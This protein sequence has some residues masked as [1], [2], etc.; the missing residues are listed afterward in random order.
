MEKEPTRDMR[1]LS[2][3]EIYSLKKD[4]VRMKKNK[5]S[6]KQI[7]VDLN[8]SAQTV[9]RVWTAYTRNGS[10]LRPAK[11]G[12]KDGECTILSLEQEREIKRIIV[13]KTPE[14]FKMLFMLWTREAVCQLIK[15]KYGIEMSLRSMSN[16]LER[17]GMTCQRPTKRAY[18]QDDVKVKEF[19]EK[20]YPSIKARAEAENGEIY[21]GDETGISNQE[22]YLRG[23]APKGE[24]PVLKVEAKR[25][26]IN[27]I[28]AINN[29]GTVRFLL[30]ETKMTQ[31]R[32][33]EFMER[34]IVDAKRKVFF[35]VDNL[36]VHHGNI[37]KE[38]L[39]ENKNRIELFFIP[40]Y[41]P[42]LNPDEYLNHA[43]KLGVHSEIPPRTK[44]DLKY[45]T[46]QFMYDLKANP[47]KVQAFFK[48]KKI[49]YQNA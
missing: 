12:R 6:Q 23:F 32:F 3:E 20:A 46:T 16:Y 22:H 40:P 39:A 36:K 31:Q 2:A 38:W 8:V 47:E 9:V 15:D 29:Y 35:I 30:Y 21:W 28:S 44:D 42:E 5:R 10:V 11:R 25:E 34:L 14:Q 17:W 33:I 37:V 45:K 26:R 19:K 43:L 18:K 41:S 49:S 4:I 48:H 24:P 7:V 1:R 13:D 27:M